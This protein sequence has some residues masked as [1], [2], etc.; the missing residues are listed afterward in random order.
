MIPCKSVFALDEFYKIFQYLHVKVVK[1][2]MRK[3]ENR[4]INYWVVATLKCIHVGRK[5]VL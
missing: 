5:G 3:H 1:G 4:N 2:H